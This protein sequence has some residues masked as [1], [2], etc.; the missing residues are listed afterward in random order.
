MAGELQW[1]QLLLTGTMCSLIVGVVAQQH[2]PYRGQ[3]AIHIIYWLLAI[4]RS[5]L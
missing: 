3:G 5:G 2:D 4:K 1:Q